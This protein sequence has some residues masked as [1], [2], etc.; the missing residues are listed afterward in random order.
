ML[1]PFILTLAIQRSSWDF[2]I[3]TLRKC[4]RTGDWNYPEFWRTGLETAY[5][6]DVVAV[7]FKFQRFLLRFHQQICRIQQYDDI[8]STKDLLSY[9]KIYFQLCLTPFRIHDTI[10]SQSGTGLHR[11][12]WVP[13]MEMWIE[14]TDVLWYAGRTSAIF[15]RCVQQDVSF[16][17]RITMNDYGDILVQNPTYGWADVEFWNWVYE[18]NDPLSRLLVL[19]FAKTGSFK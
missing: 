14:N 5:Q 19:A 15:A 2:F 16:T 4:W 8:I 12:S 18:N 1:G 11:Q 3:Q 6:N 7:K 13:I 17:W 9:T 10:D